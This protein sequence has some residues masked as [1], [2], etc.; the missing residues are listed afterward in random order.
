MSRSRRTQ[1][2]FPTPNQSPIL[3]VARKETVPP[4]P[5][6]PQVSIEDLSPIGLAVFGVTKLVTTVLFEYCAGFVTG[7]FFGTLVGTPGFVFKPMTPG[8]PQVFRKEVSQRLGRMNG[9]SLKW[10]QGL[11][12]F[13]STFKGCDCAVRLVR[14]NKED[15]WNEI[16]GSAA[17][18]AILSRK[19]KNELTVYLAKNS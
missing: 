11:G 16:L 13:S 8:V 15:L 10:G 2:G 12:G 6:V 17:A 14:Y 19:G 9:R 18:G 5:Q 3:L 1:A 4:E 7:Y